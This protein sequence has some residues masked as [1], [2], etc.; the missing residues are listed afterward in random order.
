MPP[1]GSAGPGTE[2]STKPGVFGLAFEGATLYADTLSGDVDQINTTTGAIS[3][4]LRRRLPLRHPDGPDRE[5]NE[6]R[7]QLLVHSAFPITGSAAGNR[8]SPHGLRHPWRSIYLEPPSPDR[9]YRPVEE[10]EPTGGVS[11]SE[12]METPLP[13]KGFHVAESLQA[14]GSQPSARFAPIG[15]ASPSALQPLEVTVGPVTRETTRPSEAGSRTPKREAMVGA[16]S[17]AWMG[18]PR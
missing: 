13:T 10:H 6:R 9:S 7:W 18:A 1:G 16:M 3:R 17:V 14:I 8:T 15:R 4:T 2:L 11:S 12:R 5:V